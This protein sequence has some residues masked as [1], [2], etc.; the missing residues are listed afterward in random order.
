[1]EVRSEVFFYVVKEIWRGDVDGE[2]DDDG[3]EGS[4]RG[5]KNPAR[6]RNHGGDVPPPI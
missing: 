1:M 4:K 5:D 6:V 3:E 2:D